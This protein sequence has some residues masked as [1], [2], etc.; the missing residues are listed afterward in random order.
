MKQ[1]LL[2]LPSN[3]T[4]LNCAPI[5][6]IR[7]RRR[8]YA[9]AHLA[10]KTFYKMKNKADKAKWMAAMHW[11]KGTGNVEMHFFCLKLK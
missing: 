5:N 3:S 4:Q 11:N 9:K 8:A 7:V 1:L 10:A 2:I 6:E